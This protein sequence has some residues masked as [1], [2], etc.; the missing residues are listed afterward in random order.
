[1]RQVFLY[2]LISLFL[3]NCSNISIPPFFK[4]FARKTEVL[5]YKNG[6]EKSSVSFFGNKFD[7]PMLNWD[8]DCNLISETNYE[9][10][11][12]HGYWREYHS[13]GQLMHTIKY[14][15]GQKNGYE[16]WYYKNGTVKSEVLY[17]Y[18][19]EKT[20]MLSWDESGK[21]LN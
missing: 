5:Y 17:E 9:N 4:K 13:N 16:R 6:C 1:M 20:P 19:L 21:I 2:I 14:F 12:L 7:G 15:Y 11:K 18:D 8:E 3:F 10:G